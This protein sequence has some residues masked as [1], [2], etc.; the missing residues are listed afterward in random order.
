VTSSYT[1]QL[2]ELA[3]AGDGAQQRGRLELGNSATVSGA[4]PLRAC[5][6]GTVAATTSS[7]QL[8]S[9]VGKSA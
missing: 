3:L 9:Q 8:L 1:P 4:A 6:S 5:G 2:K 7:P